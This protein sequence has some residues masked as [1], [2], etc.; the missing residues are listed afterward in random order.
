MHFNIY[1]NN[2]INYSLVWCS[3]K[4]GITRKIAS[5]GNTFFIKPNTTNF[6]IIKHSKT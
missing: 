3:V 2:I 4:R 6:N 5:F 1:F